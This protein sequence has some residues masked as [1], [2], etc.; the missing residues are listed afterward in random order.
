MEKSWHDFNCEINLGI[1]WSK[2][3]A[4][5]SATGKIKFAITDTKRYVHVVTFSTQENIKL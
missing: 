2:D 5:F 3:Y 1:T 4:I